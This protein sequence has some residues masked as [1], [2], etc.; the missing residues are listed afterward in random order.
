MK[1]M[2]MP[3]YYNALST[4]EMTYTEGGAT[5]TQALLAFFIW[6]YAWYKANTEIRDYRRKNPDTW[7]E[8]GLDY[9]AA[10]CEKS[11]TNAIYNLSC[12]YSFVVINV[13]TAG[14]GLIPSAAIIFS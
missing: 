8:K 11:I 14:L 2:M 4:E 13:G 9:F 3:A 10:D 7:L 1:K 6:P 5:A 12:A